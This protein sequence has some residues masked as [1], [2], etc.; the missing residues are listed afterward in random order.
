M[1]ENKGRSGREKGTKEWIIDGNF[2]QEREKK[3]H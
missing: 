2:M 3:G 1:R